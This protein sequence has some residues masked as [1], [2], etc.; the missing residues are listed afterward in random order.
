M[1]CTSQQKQGTIFK[2]FTAK[3][4]FLYNKL[5]P[6]IHLCLAWVPDKS[7]VSYLPHLTVDKTSS[8]VV[9]VT[10]DGEAIDISSGGVWEGNTVWSLPL[11]MN[12]WLN[13]T[14]KTIPSPA[15]FEQES[16]YSIYTLLSALIFL[17]C[18][19]SFL[20]FSQFFSVWNWRVQGCDPLKY[21][22]AQI[23]SSPS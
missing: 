2:F 12:M 23:S 22:H 13:A 16:G 8:I 15:Q 6:L 5:L 4:D 1:N 20:S 11:K 10:V 7:G 14:K 18:S 19:N 3:I 9:I 17:T 21:V